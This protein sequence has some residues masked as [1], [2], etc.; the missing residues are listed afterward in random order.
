MFKSLNRGISAPIAIII[1]VV[2]ALLVGGIVV[3]QYYGMPK[4][5]APEEIPTD[6]TADWKTYESS[7]MGFSIECPPDF[8][9][10]LDE[11]GDFSNATPDLFISTLATKAE[12]NPKGSI[13]EK[14]MLINIWTYTFSQNYFEAIY[15]VEE[16]T[17]QD[18]VD[19]IIEF[20][21]SR[22]DPEIKREDIT[23][24]GNPAIKTTHISLPIYDSSYKQLA[25]IIYT[26]K[27]ER[28]Y[29]IKARI[30]FDEQDTYLPI[31]NQML[32]TFKFSE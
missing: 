25:V 16:Y 4:E 19:E 20:I 14:M 24:A 31:F 7:I 3:W 21:K 17:F 22:R 23:I 5:E 2:C 10:S 12:V 8:E 32:S 27:G 11:R 28:V 1:I 6:E 26:K 15:E 29:E 30:D 18:Y 9:V 13:K